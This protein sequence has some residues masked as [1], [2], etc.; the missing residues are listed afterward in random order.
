MEMLEDIAIQWNLYTVEPLHSGHLYQELMSG[1]AAHK[2][3]FQ[4]M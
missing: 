1:F 3:L 2:L 4:G